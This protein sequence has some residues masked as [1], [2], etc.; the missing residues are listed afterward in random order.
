MT[1]AISD[2][3]ASNTLFRATCLGSA[4]RRIVPPN[5]QWLLA[6]Y[7]ETQRL[8]VLRGQ[9]PAST[10]EQQEFTHR[11]SNK[12]C[13]QQFTDYCLKYRAAAPASVNAVR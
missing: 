13:E 4:T 1:S 10:C 7:S 6:E 2:V 12:L 5:P 3:L 11:V 8:S 9:P